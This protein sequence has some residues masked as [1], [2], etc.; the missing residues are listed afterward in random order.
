MVL[1]PTSS[2][3]DSTHP[4]Q[5]DNQS[6]ERFRPK[7]VGLLQLCVVGWA[8]EV[9][10]HSNAARSECCRETNLWSRGPHD[11]VT[12]A[13]YELNWLPV[14]EQVTF[15]LYTLM[16]LIHTVCS[17]SYMSELVTSTYSIASCFRLRCAS[18][19][20]Y[21]NLRLVSSCSANY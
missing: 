20:R 12:P 4:W 1:P 17:P 2:E 8:T 19:R 16:H 7:S 6:D 13:L 10:H 5:V 15:K 14:E 3:A 11:H 18:S 9:N 21:E